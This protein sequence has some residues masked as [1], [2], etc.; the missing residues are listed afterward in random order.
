MTR[1]IF[2]VDAFTNQPFKGNP[3]GVMI[4]DKN[5]PA[6]LMQNIAMEMNLSETAF[7]IPQENDFQIRYFTPLKEVDLCGHATLASAHIIYETG[8]LRKEKNIHFKAKGG[9]LT[10][11]K[12]GEYISMNFPAYPINRIDLEKDFK[13]LVGFQPIEM[14][15]SLYDW[16]ILISQSEEEIKNAQPKFDLL[17]NNGLGHLMISA[18]SEK[19]NTDFVLRCFAPSAG[20]NEDP[21]TGSAHCAL[22]PYWAAKLQKSEL[23]SLQLSKRTGL[24]KTRAINNRV[25]IKG[26]A[27]TVFEAIFRF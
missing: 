7:I 9:D 16:V 18:K 19:E 3:A 2:Q 21:V 11:T 27:L 23:N 17:N 10:I 26:K 25:E 13:N 5:F 14:Y 4:V 8:L 15:A 22:T 24:L 1:K 12:E 6:E 20:I